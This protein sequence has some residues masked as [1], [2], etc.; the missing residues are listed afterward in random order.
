MEMTF[1]KAE[2]AELFPELIALVVL[3]GNDTDLKMSDSISLEIITI[4]N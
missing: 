3:M 2:I 4:G 1:N